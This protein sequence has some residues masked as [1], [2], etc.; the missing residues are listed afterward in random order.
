M[1]LCKFVSGYVNDDKD[2]YFV[3]IDWANAFSFSNG[4]IYTIKIYFYYSFCIV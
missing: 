1:D 2:N 3:D 4:N